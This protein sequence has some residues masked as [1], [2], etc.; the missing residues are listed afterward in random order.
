MGYFARLLDRRL[1]DGLAFRG[2]KY[3]AGRSGS[4]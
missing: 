3:P 2:T 1:E 4:N